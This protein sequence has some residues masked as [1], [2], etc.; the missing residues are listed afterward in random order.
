MVIRA[1]SS[2]APWA[3]YA[4]VGNQLRRYAVGPDGV[5][6][7]R[8][9]LRLPQNIQFA[10]FHPHLPILYVACS[11]GGVARQG[12]THCLFQ[13]GPAGDGLAVLVAPI[14]LPSRPLH[15]MVDLSQQTLALAYNRPAG[16]SF[17]HLDAAGIAQ[18]SNALCNDVERVGHFPHEILPIPGQPGWLLTCR[19]DDA[20][21]STAEN[22]GSLRLLRRALGGVSAT[23]VVAPGG[24]MGFG[25]RN[26]AFHPTLP[27]LYCVLERQNQMAVFRFVDGVLEEHPRWTVDLL[28][29][30]EE[31]RRPQLGGAIVLHPTGRSA[32]VV[33]RA[34]PAQRHGVTSHRWGE[35][36]VVAFDLDPSNG[37]PRA[38]QREALPGVHARCLSLSND[39]RLLVAAIRQNSVLP[40]GQ[41]GPLE[42]PA[43]LACFAVDCTGRLS[44]VQHF[45][46]DVGDEQ[47][48]WAAFAPTSHPT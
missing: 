17:H 2:Q 41:D 11:N 22:P 13:V 32:Y 30:P 8:A 24:G 20:T 14:P 39:G 37:E 23:Q 46:V 10:C 16:I 15:L 9:S 35:N 25:P 29:H 26:C 19:G 28:E 33:N 31:L 48:F 43:G 3:L 5:V 1:S 18:P 38:T 36:S 42:Q 40:F 34:H 45:P 12:D 7:Q 4:S 47:L 27:V 21:A 6:A 44:F